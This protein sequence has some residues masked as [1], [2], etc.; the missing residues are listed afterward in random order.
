MAQVLIRD[1]DSEVV[2]RLK[3]RARRNER[4]LEAELRHIL[5]E[6]ADKSNAE[7]LGEILEIRKSFEGR[8]FPS[9]ST[10]L[11]RE[12]RDR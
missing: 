11:I 7:F 5:A 4:S 10:D 2:D 12:D 3:E 9:D 1:M 6:A 8:T